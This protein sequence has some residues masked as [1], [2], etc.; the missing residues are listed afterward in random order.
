ME[1]I[2]NAALMGCACDTK[3]PVGRPESEHTN[4]ALIVYFLT[5][6][7]CTTGLQGAHS[8]SVT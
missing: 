2:A 8:C 1:S 7:L 4:Y 6:R 5:A 3:V